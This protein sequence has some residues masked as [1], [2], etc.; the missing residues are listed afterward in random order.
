MGSNSEKT[1]I[2]SGDG[3]V[4]FDLL[5]IFRDTSR[6]VIKVYLVMDAMMETCSFIPKMVIAVLCQ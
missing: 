2:V 5:I 1:E 6:K 3:S 4:K